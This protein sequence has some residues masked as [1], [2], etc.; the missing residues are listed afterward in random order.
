MLQLTYLNYQTK[1]AGPF[2]EA[3]DRLT[4][5]A[6]TNQTTYHLFKLRLSQTSAE[7]KKGGR[8]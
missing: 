6:T 3:R 5:Q 8:K 4:N 1:R 2:K 7:Q